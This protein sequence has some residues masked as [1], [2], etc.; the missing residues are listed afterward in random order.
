M[1]L[2]P[3]HQIYSGSSLLVL[4]QIHGR[5]ALRQLC[6]S[7]CNLLWRSVGNHTGGATSCTKYGL[8]AEVKHSKFHKIVRTK[9]T[10]RKDQRGEVSPSDK[11]LGLISTRRELVSDN[12]SEVSSLSLYFRP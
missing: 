1:K 8:T 5:V 10:W 12:Y 7:V 9:V 11:T 3:C 4:L 2:P 6:F